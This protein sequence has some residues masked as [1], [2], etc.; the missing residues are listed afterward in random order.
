MLDTSLPEVYSSFI[1]GTGSF[2]SKEDAQNFMAHIEESFKTLNREVF[3]LNKN[4]IVLQDLLENGL[5]N[6]DVRLGDLEEDLGKKPV[7]LEREYDAPSLWGSVSTIA[8]LISTLRERKHSS[9]TDESVKSI[10]DLALNRL[11]TKNNN[12][13][14]AMRFNINSIKNTLIN[15]SRNFKDKIS[16][17]SKEIEYLQTVTSSNPGFTTS[18]DFNQDWSTEVQ[19]LKN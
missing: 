19:E 4:Q 17:N 11:E 16:S 7:H 6:L 13:F 2:S 10:V 1:P 5:Q 12:G 14:D 15:V 3:K 18:G 9:L 8:S